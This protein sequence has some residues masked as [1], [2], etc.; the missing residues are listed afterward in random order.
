MIDTAELIRRKQL[1]ETGYW[2]IPDN[3]DTSNFNF[4]WRPYEY[5]RPYIHQ[6]GTQW[7]KTGGPRFIVPQN[8]GVKYQTDQSVIMLPRLDYFKIL[9]NDIEFDYSW[10]PDDT[11]PSFIWVF[12]N[13]WNTAIDEPTV[14]YRVKGAINKKYITDVIAKVPP[15]TENWNILIEGATIDQSWRPN[16]YDPSY[17]YVFGNQWYDVTTDSVIE[18]RVPGATKKKYMN[19]PV[20]NLL[21]TTENWHVLIEGAIIDQSWYPNPYDPPYIYVFGNQWH[22]ATTEPTIEYHV[23]TAV[24]RKYM[25]DMT[26]QLPPTTENWIVPLEEDRQTFDFSWRPNPFA[27]PRIYQWEDNGPIYTVTNAT[28]FSLMTRHDTTPRIVSKYYIDT[29]L[30]DLIDQHPKEV[31]WALNR[32]LNYDSF[33][34]EWRPS[35]ENGRYVNVFGNELSKDVSTYYVNAFIYHTGF[36]EFNYIDDHESEITTDI[37]MFYVERGTHFDQY[38]ELKLKFP[39]LQ[40]TRYYYSWVDTITRCVKKSTTKLIWI[41]SSDIDYSDFKFDFYPTK[42]QRDMVHI[43]GTQWSQWGNTYMINTKTFLKDTE[44]VRVLEHLQN[45]NFVKKRVAK[46]TENFHDIVYIDHGNDSNTLAQIKQ[47]CPASSVTVL[48][49]KD[50]YLRTLNDWVTR[51]DK[52]DIKREHYMWVCSSICDYADFDFSWLGDPFKSEQLHVFSSSLGNDKQQFGD[53]FLLNLNLFKQESDSLFRLEDYGHSINYIQYISAARLP[54][55]VIMHD[56]DSQVTAIKEIKNKSWPY[57]ELINRESNLTQDQNLIPNLWNIHERSLLVAGNGGSRIVVPDVAIDYIKSEVYDYPYLY[58][59]N[60][61]DTLTPLDVVFISNGE[62]SADS[63]YE[64]LLEIAAANKLPNRI[65]RVKDVK[66]RVASQHAAA[67]ASETAWYFLIN[68]K[69]E[70]NPEFDF[71]WQ[72][73]QLQRAK[74]Y[75]FKAIN[76]VND[77]EYGH[78]AIVANNR[79][80][81]LDTIVQGLDFTLDSPHE[82]VDANCGIARFNTDPWTTWRTAFREAI[83]LSYSTDD[84]SVDR[85][86]SWLTVG[87]GTHGEWSTKGAQDAVAYFNKVKGNLTELMKSYD[88]KWLEKLYKK[89][90]G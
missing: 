7:Q 75:I 81:T 12:G 42:W 72:A 41:L 37:D 33:D 66:G 74:H 27:E 49:Y 77:L 47:K 25:I 88:W 54:H 48:K 76:P 56:H 64:R 11:E 5:D 16:P 52:T 80:L 61:R 28:H 58:N 2:E 9:I 59:M 15:T 90:Y 13:Q 68:G 14:E 55:P 39:K 65:V 62:P 10:H 85:L 30:E 6:F 19:E 79:T 51:L 70:V 40:K 43:F 3:L 87:N 17:I 4:D 8:E 60:L 86:N 23:P 35:E 24:D 32:E 46:V 36:K 50:N 83:K 21:P 26:A 20:A 38:D 89:T 63:N 84:D 69:L 44:Y 67:N 73:D 78:Q 71:T 1:W 31:F 29:T 82:I 18:Y 57:Y 34:F 22:D 53:T 45:I